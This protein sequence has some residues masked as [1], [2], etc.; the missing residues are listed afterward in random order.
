MDECK[1]CGQDGAGLNEDGIC[2]HCVDENLEQWK[3]ELRE[4]LQSAFGKG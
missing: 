4:A 1:R 2:H 3:D